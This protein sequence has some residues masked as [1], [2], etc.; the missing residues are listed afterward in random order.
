[1]EEVPKDGAIFVSAYMQSKGKLI[2]IAYIFPVCL[3]PFKYERAVICKAQSIVYDAV[4][5]NVFQ[6][7]HTMQCL[8]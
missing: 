5:F 2:S 8:V 6:D 1:M 4:T 7:N 3:P